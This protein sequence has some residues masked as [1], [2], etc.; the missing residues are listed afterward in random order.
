M[1]HVTYIYIMIRETLCDTGSGELVTRMP[2][3]ICGQAVISKMTTD[4][5]CSTLTGG[6]LAK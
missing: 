2:L 4:A 1:S 6:D 3:Q 5:S